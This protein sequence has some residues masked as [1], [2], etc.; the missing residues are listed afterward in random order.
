MFHVKGK[1]VGDKS[2]NNFLVE[3]LVIVQR[4]HL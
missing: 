1:N 3:S 4:A 2:F